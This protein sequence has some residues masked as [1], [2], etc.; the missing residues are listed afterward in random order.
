MRFDLGFG[1]Y[2]TDDDGKYNNVHELNELVHRLSKTVY[3]L[4]HTKSIPPSTRQEIDALAQFAHDH[5]C[6]EEEMP[7][8]CDRLLAKGKGF[9]IWHLKEPDGPSSTE[10]TSSR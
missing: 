9:R 2:Q 3:Y 5:S 4:N 7:E 10:R 8:G 1:I 6:Y